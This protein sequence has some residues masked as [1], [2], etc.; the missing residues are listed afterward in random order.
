MNVIFHILVE[1]I[2]DAGRSVLEDVSVIVIDE[3]D[4]ERLVFERK[5][6]ES[7]EKFS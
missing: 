6:R 7:F 5:P 2:E 1:L 4:D 3:F